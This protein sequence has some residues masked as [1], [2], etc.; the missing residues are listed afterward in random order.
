MGWDDRPDEGWFSVD[1]NG[2]PEEEASRARRRPSFLAVLLGLVVVAIAVVAWVN[3]SDASRPTSTPTPPSSTPSA[4]ASG[5]SATDTSPLP[6]RIGAQPPATSSLGGA[7]LGRTAPWDLFILRTDELVRI[8][9]A[10]GRMTSTPMQLPEGSVLIP[11]SDR[12]L[13]QDVYDGTGRVVGE[14]GRDRAAAGFPAGFLAPVPGKDRVWWAPT[15]CCAGAPV[16]QRGA[17]GRVVAGT[18][19]A[20][21]PDMWPGSIRSDGDDALVVDGTDGAYRLDGSGLRR[22]TTGVVLGAARRGWVVNECDD[23]HVCR[24]ALVDRAGYARHDLGPGLVSPL[25]GSMDPTGHLAVV[26]ENRDTGNVSFLVDLDT[27]V[28]TQVAGV[29]PVTGPSDAA[30]VVWSPGSRWFVVSDAAVG[31]VAVEAATGHLTSL[32][33]GNAPPLGIAGRSPAH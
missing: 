17:D 8:E 2:R 23:A 27:G 21:P 1:P 12:V 30:P 5:R 14:D 6:T 10:T 31:V 26:I 9:M 16:E 32:L 7:P 33:G 15:D 13:A 28:R 4:S 25:G 3:H 11:F 18:A 29:S 24:L 19:V 22:I 20:L